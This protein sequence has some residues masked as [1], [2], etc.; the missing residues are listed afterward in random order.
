MTTAGCR[1]CRVYPSIENGHVNGHVLEV[2]SSTEPC[3][4]QKRGSNPK[5]APLKMRIP[6][7]QRGNMTSGKSTDAGGYGCWAIWTGGSLAFA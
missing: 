2:R 7:L 5:H 6:N 3:N 1:G 4:L